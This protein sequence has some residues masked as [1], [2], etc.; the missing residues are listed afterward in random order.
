LRTGA[1][2]PRVLEDGRRPP[3]LKKGLGGRTMAAPTQEPL[4]HQSANIYANR[5]KDD[6]ER[7]V[8]ENDNALRI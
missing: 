8:S 7:A 1:S 3:S 5:S 6:A 4:R 2:D